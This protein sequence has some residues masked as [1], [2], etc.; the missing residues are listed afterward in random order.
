MFDGGVLY[1]SDS[2]DTPRD[3]GFVVAMDRVISIRTDVRTD[4]VAYSLLLKIVL[5]P[6][7]HAD[8]V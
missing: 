3:Q 8:V 5:M 4:T 1:L 6:F 7:L 2:T